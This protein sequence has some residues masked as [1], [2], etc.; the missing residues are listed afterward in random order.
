MSDSDKYILNVKFDGNDMFLPFD[1]KFEL[2]NQ[3]ASVINLSDVDDLETA[4]SLIGER[5]VINI[6]K[7]IKDV[8][9]ANN[10]HITINGNDYFGRVT[11]YAMRIDKNG[12][13]QFLLCLGDTW[14]WKS[15]KYFGVQ[16]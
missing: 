6:D 2:I 4:I 11:P 14:V 3:N 13:P 8:I 9:I 16:W 1:Y 12:Y 15:A 7:D 5:G 10:K